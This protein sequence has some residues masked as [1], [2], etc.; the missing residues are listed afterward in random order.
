MIG[1]NNAAEQ[2]SQRVQ[3]RVEIL[4]IRRMAVGDVKRL[5]LLRYVAVAAPEILGA[6]RPA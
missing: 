2:V 5:H 3:C 4:A 6:Q 1:R